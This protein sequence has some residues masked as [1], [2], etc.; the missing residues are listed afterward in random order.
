MPFDTVLA[1]KVK[2]WLQ[3]HTKKRIEEKKMFK[4]LTFMVDGKMCVCISGDNLLCRFNPALQENIAGKAGYEEM[5]MNGRSYQGYCYVHPE[6]FRSKK[7]FEYWL[8]LCLDYNP[9]AKASKK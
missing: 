2:S 6:G 7:D 5:I 9:Q 1:E 4:G 3:D 8:S